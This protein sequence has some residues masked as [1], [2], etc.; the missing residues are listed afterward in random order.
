MMGKGLKALLSETS[1]WKDVLPIHHFYFLKRKIYR[2]LTFAREIS[3]LRFQKL[4]S[5]HVF[6]NSWDFSWLIRSHICNCYT[7]V[8][9]FTTEQMGLLHRKYLPF[10][11]CTLGKESEITNSSL[12]S[13]TWAFFT[14]PFHTRFSCSQE[15]RTTDKKV[16]QLAVRIQTAAGEGVHCC[17][18][19]IYS[20]ELTN[21]ASGH[22]KE[23][24]TK[25][26]LFHQVPRHLP[27]AHWPVPA[28]HLQA[29]DRAD[30][31]CPLEVVMLVAFRVSFI[32]FPGRIIR[33]L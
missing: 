17:L 28:I 11:F 1:L 8:T 32:S 33:K 15:Q 12:L 4:L 5:N 30:E 22:H 31:T 20:K 18:S 13:V 21:Q 19:A 2:W 27:H 3:T 14:A 16:E 7:L 23:A 24:L 26:V 6:M 9:L 10:A 29:H 25:P